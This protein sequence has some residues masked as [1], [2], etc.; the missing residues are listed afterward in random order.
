MLNWLVKDIKTLNRKSIYSRLTL[1]QRNKDIEEKLGYSFMEP[2]LLNYREVD[3]F[4]RVIFFSGEEKSSSLQLKYPSPATM[5]GANGGNCEVW[6]LGKRDVPVDGWRGAVS[7]VD[8][9]S[10]K[11]SELD[12][13]E[14]F[15]DDMC[16]AFSD[17]NAITGKVLH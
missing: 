6:R 7:V 10:C 8:K 5:R 16:S 12:L 11:H 4:H 2:R 17:A 13:D 15:D 14:C 9:H 1:N 3:E